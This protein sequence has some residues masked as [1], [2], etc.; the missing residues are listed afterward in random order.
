VAEVAQQPPQP[1]R[2]AGPA[3]VL[4][5]DEDA[6]ADPRAGRRLRERLRGWERVPPRSADRKIRQ[7]VDPEE[8]RV[9]NVLA[10]VRLSSCLDALE[11]V[12]AIDEAE[13]DQ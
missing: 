10:K 3:V 5:D 7:L 1:R 6:V 2:A 8:R 12:S 11:R 9:G 13:V 4:G